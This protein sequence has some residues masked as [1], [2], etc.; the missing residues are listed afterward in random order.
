VLVNWVLV[1]SGILKE[2]NI[3]VLQDLPCKF[4]LSW[5]KQTAHGPEINTIT[6]VILVAKKCHSNTNV[7]FRE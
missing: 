1:E 7:S 2:H 3:E 4:P 5:L 6:E